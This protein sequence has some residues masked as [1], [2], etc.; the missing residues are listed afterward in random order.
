[1]RGSIL[2][3]LY[4][5]LCNGRFADMGVKPTTDIFIL[6]EFAPEIY[7]QLGD[8]KNEMSERIEDAVTDLC[9]MNERSGF[10]NGVKVGVR[11]A[12]D[13]FGATVT[14]NKE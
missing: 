3:E 4:L 2:E 8:A 14:D 9:C 11:L 13:I 10:L 12:G 6:E 5:S 7:E 1:M